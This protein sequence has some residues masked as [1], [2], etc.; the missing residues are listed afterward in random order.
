VARGILEEVEQRDEQKP[1]DDP[2]R[3]VLAEIVHGGRPLS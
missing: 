1:D 3:Q 2:E